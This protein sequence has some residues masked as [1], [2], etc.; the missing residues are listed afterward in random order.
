MCTFSNKG[1]GLKICMQGL[2]HTRCGVYQRNHQ[3]RC[4]CDGHCDG[5][6]E[7]H[8]DAEIL[9]GAAQEPAGN[10]R[11][12][13]EAHSNCREQAVWLCTRLEPCVRLHGGRLCGSR[14]NFSLRN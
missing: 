14:Q 11:R 12:L 13:D 7:G 1:L 8:C 2:R 4:H 5:H 6:C 10:D 9:H 3:R